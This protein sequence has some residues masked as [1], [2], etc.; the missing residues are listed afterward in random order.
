MIFFK[1]ATAY[2]WQIWRLYGGWIHLQGAYWRGKPWRRFY[3]RWD[4]SH[5]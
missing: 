5:D 1:G 3:V 2:E 4:F